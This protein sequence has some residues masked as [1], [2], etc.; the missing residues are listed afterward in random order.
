MA[1][2]LTT[3]M[4]AGLSADELKANGA[5]VIES[6]YATFRNMYVNMLSGFLVTI[7]E[8]DDPQA[9]EREFERLGF[10]FESITEIHFALDSE[11]LRAMLADGA[12]S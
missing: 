1:T 10:P 12:A 9:L 8:A 5:E 6:K 4:A 3:H 11:G 7:Y 2:Y